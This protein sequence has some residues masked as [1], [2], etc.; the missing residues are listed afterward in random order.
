MT[1]RARKTAASTE[2]ARVVPPLTL[3]LATIA[4]RLIPFNLTLVGWD[5]WILTGISVRFARVYLPTLEWYDVL[6]PTGYSYPPF[7]FWLNGGTI[8]LLGDQPLV[9]RLIT[10]LSDAACVVAICALGRQLA[11][12]FG[13]WSAGLLAFASLYLSFHE[14]VTIDFLLSFWVIL[15]LRWLLRSVHEARPTYLVWAIIFSS[16]AVF[17]KYHGVVYHAILCGLVVVLP[18]TRRML[19]GRMLGACAIAA[20][21]LPCVLLAL[22]ALTWHFYGYEKTHLAEVIRVMGWTSYVQDPATGDVVEATWPYYFQYLWHVLGPAVCALGA[23][24]VAYAIGARRRDLLIVVAIAGL[25]F[26]WASTASLKN[27]RYILP[28]V[29]MLFPLA[30]AMLHGI[31]ERGRYGKVVATLVL[32]VVVLFGMWG[33]R[34]RIGAYLSDAAVHQRAYDYIRQ[35]VPADAV[36]FAESAPF[37]WGMSLRSGAVRPTRDPE[38]PTAFDDA[39]YAVMHEWGRRLIAAGAIPSATGYL[40][41]REAAMAEWDTVLDLG[42]GAGRVTLL[43]KR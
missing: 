40:D 25:W 8:Y 34:V 4:T 37:Q 1:A 39:D 33:T 2:V 41:R 35:N 24:S 29:T 26:L 7:F 23:A 36:V 28:G 42:T 11:G 10:I 17:T 6:V 19:R 22:D 3:F 16:V 43:R 18:A 9:F 13:A 21:A 30:G 15:S 31:V 32:A 20:L 27:A 14:T 38:D 5:E 12:R